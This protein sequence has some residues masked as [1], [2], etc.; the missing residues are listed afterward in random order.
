MRF[1]LLFGAMGAAGLVAAVAVSAASASISGP[2]AANIAGA[3]VAGRSGTDPAA[4]IHVKK[5]GL[6]NVSMSAASPISALKVK[7]A[8]AGFSWTVKNG[9]ASGS[10]WIRTLKVNDYATWGVG[11]YQV[12]GVSTGPAVSCTGTALVRVEGN[13]LTTVAGGTA[14]GLSILAVVG[15]LGGGLRGRRRVGMVPAIGLFSGL[16]LGVG[17]LTLLQQY[18]V[19]YPTRAVAL[20][21]ILSGVLFGLLVPAVTHALTTGH[22]GPWHFHA[23]AGH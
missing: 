22:F 17:I 5:G 16:F 19:V 6:V 21:A 20:A 18:S 15:L 11:L 12:S 2:C 4:A 1:R 23:A 14:L 3:A 8:F 10:S 9:A 13:P 7:L